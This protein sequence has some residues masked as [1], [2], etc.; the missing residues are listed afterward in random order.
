MRV[1]PQQLSAHLQ[2]GL[3]PIYLLSGDEPLQL[4]EAAD[5]IRQ[6]A[7][8]LGYSTREILEVDAR[9]DWSRLMGIADSLSLFAERR[10]IDLRIPSGKPGIDGSKALSTYL[11]RLP[12][13]VLLL[14]T[15]PK[16]EK[17]QLN[18]KWFKEIDQVGVMVQIWSVDL[19]RLQPWIEARMRSAGLEPT[20]EVVAMLSE[21]I[22]GNLLAARQEIEKLLLRYGP[23]IITPEQLADSVTDS[24]RYD[25]FGLVD[26]ALAG[27]IDRCIKILDGLQA[28]GTPEA[29]VL[30]ALTR[31]LRLLSS[32]ANEVARGQSVRQTIASRREVWEKR[33]PLVAKG[34][35]RLPV[36]A[37]RQLLLLCGEADRAIKGW[38]K[39]DP[40]LLM[41]E[42]LVR[43]TGVSVL[44]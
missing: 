3:A 12:D 32:L 6:Q 30:W 9:F 25:V 4:I 36:A 43:M 22:E 27:E 42:I 19:H 37:W 13:D 35:Q 7:L 33:K 44:G 28:E 39:R 21:R 26:T 16:L 1:A 17:S 20:G 38:E 34:L 11:S 31:E 40:W 5:A 18:S 8:R 41:Q 24:A 23:G 2:R 14:I 29:V 10:I 15:L